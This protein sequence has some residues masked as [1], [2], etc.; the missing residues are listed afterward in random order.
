MSNV[1]PTVVF[2]RWL[3][4]PSVPVEDIEARRVVLSNVVEHGAGDDVSVARRWLKMIDAELDARRE[5]ERLSME[6]WLKRHS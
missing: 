3:E 5:V 6:N 1:T 4:H 2:L